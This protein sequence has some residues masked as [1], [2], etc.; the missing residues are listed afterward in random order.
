M[1]DTG[2]RERTVRWADPMIG[3]A[4]ALRL[5][6][7]DYL[8]AIADGHIPPPPIGTLTNLR[9]LRFGQ[10]EAVFELVPDES[11]YNPIGSVHGGVLATACDSTAGCAVHTLLPAG[12]GYT[13]LELTTNYL[14]RVTTATGPLTCTGTV[15]H[16]GRT[17]A[18]A[19]ARLTDQVGRLHAYATTTCAVFDLTTGRGDT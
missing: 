6:G 10:G 4:Q 8:Q 18:L 16:A 9:P 13:T 5:P 1:P 2:T 14:R 3:A 17:Q 12:R 15:L 11:L 7:L 19:Q